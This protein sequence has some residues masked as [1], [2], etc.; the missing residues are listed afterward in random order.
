MEQ[1]VTITKPEI[2][3]DVAGIT[4]KQFQGLCKS[5]V[6]TQKREIEVDE[7]HKALLG[8]ALANSLN[9]KPAEAKKLI[10]EKMLNLQNREPIIRISDDKFVVTKLRLNDFNR[11]F[12]KLVDEYKANVPVEDIEPKEDPA[13][14]KDSA[15]TSEDLEPGETGE[16][17]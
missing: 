12:T 13:S 7:A 10:E 15:E 9:L 5:F 8:N 2:F 17:D 4:T 1:D 6:G 16:E 11:A 14:S 3:A